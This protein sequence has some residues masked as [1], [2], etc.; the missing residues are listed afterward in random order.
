MAQMN[1]VRSAV[2]SIMSFSP[3]YL[4]RGFQPFPK[5]FFLLFSLHL[6]IN[7]R[8]RKAFSAFVHL[9]RNNDFLT[10]SRER[11]T[12]HILSCFFLLQATCHAIL[13]SAA[14]L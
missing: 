13:L 2:F 12:F 8:Q 9:P 14:R 7:L 3:L 4:T 10:K 6:R 1:N 11:T 5:C